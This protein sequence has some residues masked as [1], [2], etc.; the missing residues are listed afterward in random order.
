MENFSNLPA[1]YSVW[2][3]AKKRKNFRGFA[4]SLHTNLEPAFERGQAIDSR[5]RLNDV[6]LKNYHPGRLSKV[7]VGCVE[8]ETIR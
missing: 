5:Q 6:L 2:Q 1:H 7:S 3:E 4:E 8:H